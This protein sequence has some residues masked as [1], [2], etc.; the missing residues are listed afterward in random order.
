MWHEADVVSLT[1]DVGS[2][3]DSQPTLRKRRIDLHDE[4]PA[5]EARDRS[6]VADE[7]EVRLLVER[8]AD[9]VG[10][11]GKQERIAVRRRIDGDFKADIAAGTRPILDD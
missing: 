10:R 3:G 11:R 9:R 6:D 8:G 1:D 4:R 2:R 7:I 5:H